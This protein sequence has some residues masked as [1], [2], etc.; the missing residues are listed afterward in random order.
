MKHRN[1]GQNL[2]E[3]P[4]A[5]AVETENFLVW[6]VDGKIRVCMRIPTICERKTEV[7]FEK[8]VKGLKVPNLKKRK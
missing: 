8:K 6:S 4:A 1:G 7:D 2:A 3:L 5:A